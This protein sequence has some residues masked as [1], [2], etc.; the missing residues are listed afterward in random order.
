[1]S[2]RSA[3]AWD[4]TIAIVTPENIAFEYELAGPFRRVPAYA[5]DVVMRWTVIL[6]LYFLLTLTGIAIGFQGIGGLYVASL[7]IVYFLISWFYGT[8]ME[9]YF[10]GRTLANGR[11]DC[12]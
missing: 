12:E 9:T 2:M 8:F 1:M 6:L 7:L 4:T 3:N 11:R 5:I 10:N